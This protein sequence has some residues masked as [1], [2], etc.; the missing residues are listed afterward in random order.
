[1]GNRGLATQQIAP[2]LLIGGDSVMYATVA[3]AKL[4]RGGDEETATWE[5]AAFY[6]G[7]KSFTEGKQ[8]VPTRRLASADVGL[9]ATNPRPPG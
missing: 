3:C 9:W 1:M 5:D 4:G 7:Q 6:I 8:S 2:V